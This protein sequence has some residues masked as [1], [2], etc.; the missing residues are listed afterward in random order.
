MSNDGQNGW[1]E[2]SRLVL[3]ELESL[4]DSI[5][6][7]KSELQDVKQELTKLQAKE[8]KVD[9]LRQWKERIDDVASPTQMRDLIV[10]VE[11]LKVFKTKAITIFAVVQFGMAAAMWLMKIM[12]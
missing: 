3:K 5:E 7:L 1:N 6:G 11:E 8:D 4:N 10:S 2:Y 9:E 12:E